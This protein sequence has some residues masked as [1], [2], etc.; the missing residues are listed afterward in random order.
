MQVLQAKKK[1]EVGFPFPSLPG[2]PPN[3]EI[4]LVS[5]E[6]PA[7]QMDLTPLEPLGKPLG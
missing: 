7:L 4:K 5:P 1:T 3:L 2:D 6:S